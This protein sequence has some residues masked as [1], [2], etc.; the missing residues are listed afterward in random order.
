MTAAA[1]TRAIFNADGTFADAGEL[2]RAKVLNTVAG[3]LGSLWFALCLG[4]YFQLFV[5]SLGASDMEIALLSAIPSVASIVQIA[6]A[7]VVERL[8]RRKPFWATAEYT[9]RLVFGAVIALPFVFSPSHYKTAVTMVLV[10]LGI[11]YFIGTAAFSPWYSW[12]ADIIPQKERGRFWGWRSAII[13]IVLIVFFPLFGRILD[14]FTGEHQWTGFAIV[15]GAGLVLGM[16]DLT[17]HMF[18]PEPPMKREREGVDLVAM[19]RKPLK[20]PNFRRFFLGWGLWSFATLIATPFYSVYYKENLRLEYSFIGLLSSAALAAAVVGSWFWGFVADKLGSKPV[21]SLCLASSIPIPIMYFFATPDNAK[22]ILTIQA[23]YAGLVASGTNVGFTNLLIGLSP[24]EGRG[25]FIAVF[26]ATTGVLGGIAPVISGYI[27]RALPNFVLAGFGAPFDQLTKYH[28]LMIIA[29]L[30]YVFCMPLFLKIREV[31]STPIGV[32]LGNLLLASPVR[33]FAQLTVL[34]AGLS[35]RSRARAV[36]SLAAI[37]SRLATDDLLARIDD[38]SVVVREEAIHALGEIGAPDAVAPLLE[39]LKTPVAHS[40]LSIIRA[41]GMIRDEHAL[42]ALGDCLSDEDR[43]VRAAAARALGEMGSP[44]AIPA[45]KELIRREKLPQVVANAVEALGEIGTS[46]DM[47]EILPYLSGVKNPILKRQMALAV[48]N[49]LGR[50]DEFYRILSRESRSRGREAAKLLA[51]LTGRLRRRGAEG[52]LP[53]LVD[54][55]KAAYLANDSPRCV[56]LLWD[57]GYLIARDVYGFDGPRDMLLEVAVLRDA[58]FA[59]GLW[60]LHMLESGEVE[61]TSDDVLLG[62]YFLASAE[63]KDVP[64]LS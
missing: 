17:T 10:I 64:R 28:N 61:P 5:R 39:R 27:A 12:M 53:R 49:L 45:L 50:R 6:S 52:D 16:A 26:F 32:V 35:V 46:A 37:R 42:G 30:L 58:R 54:E 47:W 9:R 3:S 15:M 11:S 25:M 43:H 13:N 56:N 24:R 48:G 7:Y 55:F 41:L 62:L 36:R 59:A 23:V 31:G 21:F 57:T 1:E 18:I 33:T 19:V 63:Y 22:I 34:K 14:V 20:D 60:F 29:M 38:P 8:G 40:S 44:K 4:S 2:R 51:R